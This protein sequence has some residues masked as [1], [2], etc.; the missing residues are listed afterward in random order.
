MEYTALYRKYRPNS[1]DLV[2]GQE[3]IVTSL[4][5]QI[6]H[7]RIAHA[8][9]FCG[10]RGT[11]KTTLA[12]LFAAAVNCTDENKPCGKC[13]SCEDFFH[14]RSLNIIEMDA[15]SNNGVDDVRNIIEQIEYAPTDA[16]YKVY[17][18]DEVHMLSGSAFNALLKT[19]EEP[20]AHIIFILATTEPNKLPATIL[21]RCQKYEFHQIAADIIFDRL[22]YVA[23]MEKIDIDDE[24]IDYIAR[25][26]DGSMRDALSIMDSCYSFCLDNEKIDINKVTEMLGTADNATYCRMLHSIING[27][28]KGVLALVKRFSNKGMDYYRIASDFLWFLRNL[29]I[30]K[31]DSALNDIL[32][33]SK[34]DLIEMQDIADI[35]ELDRIIGYIKTLALLTQR[36]KL[37]SIKRIELE[38]TLILMCEKNADSTVDN[39]FG[40]SQ[41]HNDI[42][43]TRHTEPES[44]QA[45]MIKKPEKSEINTDEVPWDIETNKCEEPISKAEPTHM[46]K[47]SD[48]LHEQLTDI[49]ATVIDDNI[50][51]KAIQ[52]ESSGLI[53]AMLGK[54]RL[55]KK[56]ENIVI[57]ATDSFTKAFFE[58]ENNIYELKKILEKV[59]IIGY[60]IKCDLNVRDKKVYTKEQKED[61]IKEN[62][63]NVNI[64]WEE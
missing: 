51:I 59:G 32:S 18:I 45:E 47:A 63:T 1:F 41:N 40:D 28:A 29:M 58:K 17:I 30:L 25:A 52:A 44:N 55:I 50:D 53:K 6:K 57:V 56:A 14:N 8:Y 13:K 42:K 19:L 38:T 23:D 48:V 10:T 46:V 49:K 61:I 24:A 37:S 60:N 64:T 54:V 12:K 4:K 35:V 33:V 62:I 2:C 31:V 16:K 15:A 9:L 7:N 43:L 34:S 3:H 36:L 39:L 21:S 20:P 22:K 5:N 27:D 26:G 11:G